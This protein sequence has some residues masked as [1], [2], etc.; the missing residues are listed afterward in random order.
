MSA[1][2]APWMSSVVATRTYAILSGFVLRRSPAPNWGLVSEMFVFAGLHWTRPA[3]FPIGI[4]AFATL[5]LNGP[6]T[7]M[8]DASLTSVWMFLAPC[9]GSWTPLTAS[10]WTFRV[11]LKPGTGICA[12]ASLTPLSVGWPFGRSAPDRG[13]SMPILTS[14]P[15]AALAGAALA[16]P[17]ALGAALAAALAGAA[18][19]P[20]PA[21]GA[22]VALPLQAPTTMDAIARAAPTRASFMSVS[23]SFPRPARAACCPRCSRLPRRRWTT[24]FPPQGHAADGGG[25]RA[26]AHLTLHA[27]RV[28]RCRILVGSDPNAILGVARPGVVRPSVM[29]AR[30]PGAA[31]RRQVPGRARPR[32]IHCTCRVASKR[33]VSG[34]PSGI[35]GSTGTH[36]RRRAHARALV[37]DR[38]GCWFGRDPRRRRLAAAAGLSPASHRPRRGNPSRNGRAC[39]ARPSAVRPGRRLRRYG[40]SPGRGSAPRPGTGDRRPR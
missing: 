12:S 36:H 7:P 6:T 21:L 4:S 35:P 11:T 2:A 16:P 19:A 39:G 17:P 18:L 14:T 24:C 37:D 8:T 29:H 38:A 13:S 33:E 1:P 20:P 23:S 26:R 25:T 22:V 10:S 32:T 31:L 15:P 34:P 27:L 30:R 28:E 5:E 9:C 3:A 40:G